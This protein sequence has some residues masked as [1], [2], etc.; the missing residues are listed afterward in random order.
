LVKKDEKIVLVNMVM[1]EVR[2]RFF[3]HGSGLINGKFIFTF[4]YFEELDK[5]MIAVAKGGNNFFARVSIQKALNKEP[6]PMESF[7]D[8]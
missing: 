1:I 2:Q 4:F 3:W 8:N 5:G 6:N 7:S